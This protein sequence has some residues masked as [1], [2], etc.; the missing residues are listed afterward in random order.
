M[1]PKLNIDG[2]NSKRHPKARKKHDVPGPGFYTFYDSNM[3]PHYSINKEHVFGGKKRN[4]FETPGPGKYDYVRDFSDAEAYHFAKIKRTNLTL[5]EQ[6]LQYPGPTKYSYDTDLISTKTPKWT[7]S[8]CDRFGSPKTEGREKRFIKKRVNTPG[9]G[10][11]EIASK[12]CNGIPKYSFPKEKNNHQDA[13]DVA[14]FKKIQFYPSPTTYFKDNINYIPSYPFYSMS[15]LERQKI[16]GI[17]KTMMVYPSPDK[18]NP[19]KNCSSTLNRNPIWTIS[20][21]NR[22]EDEKVQGSKKI[23]QNNPGPGTYTFNNGNLPEGP[24]YT[25]S[26]LYKEPKKE[27]KPGPGTY[28]SINFADKGNEPKYTI[29]KEQ[30]GDDL[31]RIKKEGFPGPGYY[32]IKDVKL[33]NEISFPKSTK[34]KNKGKGFPGPGYYRIPTAFD[35]ISNLTREK[36]LFDPTF[37]YV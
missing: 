25:M 3:G 5:N 9:P 20:K 13:S 33:C 19:D 14:M 30:R 31:K 17:N 26:A 23:K 36:G 15:K 11:Y 28:N 32:N 37:K 34:N 6:A 4:I 7:F 8:K 10:H 1:R 21:S 29:G 12:L 22:F 18:Y 24:K 27:N 2:D 16:S 35:Y